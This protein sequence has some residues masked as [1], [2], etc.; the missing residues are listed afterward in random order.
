M[1]NTIILLLSWLAFSNLA[2]SQ[3]S[4]FFFDTRV[5]GTLSTPQTPFWLYANQNGVFPVKGS[6]LLAQA[7]FQRFYNPNNPRFFQWGG[8]AELVAHAGEQSSAFFSDL[9]ISGRAGPIELSIGQ[10]KDVMGLGDSLLTTGSL[11]MSSN[12]RPY[13]KIQIS[14][15]RFVSLLPGNDIVSFKFSY[16]DGLLGGAD[17]RYGNVSWVP[18][19][20]LH[21]KSIYVKLGGR[22]HK[23]NLYGGFNHQAMWGSEQ[24]IFSGG[25]P[26]SKAYNY[27]VFGKPWADS[28][29]GNHLGTIDIA[30]EWKMKKWNIF[31][32]R[33][34]IYEDG[35]LSNLSSIAD[36]LNGLR[37]KRIKKSPYQN[38]SINTV[39]LEF[40]YTK[41]QGG[42]DFDFGTGT[43]GRDNYFNHYVYNQGWSYRHMT[44]GTPLIAPQALFRKNLTSSGALFTTN[45][46]LYA[47]HIGIDASWKSINMLFKGTRSTNFGTYQS[48]F[49]PAVQQTSL[50]L[51]VEA[52]FHFWGENFLNV[53]LASDLGK[54]Y[55]NSNALSLGWRKSGF[56]K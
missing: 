26:T 42:N 11:A 25:L 35:S 3:D 47:Y 15:S 46:R 40:L 2:Y 9:F 21:Q 50:F 14:T 28:R 20:Y 55:P 1:R 22:S 12:F 6:F 24:K 8:G 52:P 54:L 39:L 29:V 16:S 38:F 18:D 34:T 41:N 45:N 23:L 36:G 33:Q 17:T 32:Y 48:E 53:S 19:V 37:F 56:I 10:K 31:L 49:R 4:T 7:S 43:F 44:L 5:Q 27:V 51:K 13:P 30:A